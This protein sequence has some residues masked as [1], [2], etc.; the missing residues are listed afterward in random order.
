MYKKILFILFYFS[1]SFL[2]SNSFNELF[3]DLMNLWEIGRNSVYIHFELDD[4]NQSKGRGGL[5]ITDNELDFI[6]GRGFFV[7]FDEINNNYYLTRNGRF[8]YNQMMFLVNEDGYYVI[9]P[10]YEYIHHDN[11]NFKSQYFNDIFLAVVPNDNITITSKYIIT[12]NFNR[13][14]SAG[15]NKVIETIP[16]NLSD[17]IDQALLDIDENKD[18]DN[19]EKLISLI[20]K[21]YYQLKKYYIG[22]PVN[23]SGYLTS[24]YLSELLN[25][26]EL[27]EKRLFE[28]NDIE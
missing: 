24:Q 11:F 16:I 17:L 5:I 12:S 20:Y 27:F 2:Y 19:K 13:V 28:K 3:I 8:H 1:T 18:Y 14:I 22:L 9:N 23:S 25:K 10:D 6:I 26:I 21:R 15:T 4:P 7:V